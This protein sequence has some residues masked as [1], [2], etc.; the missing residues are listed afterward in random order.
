MTHPDL[1]RLM[2]EI[3]ALPDFHGKRLADIPGE[4]RA[5]RLKWR[6]RFYR[7]ADAGFVLLIWNFFAATAGSNPTW[8]MALAMAAL[9]SWLI[10]F[11]ESRARICTRQLH[12]RAAEQ[13]ARDL[14]GIQD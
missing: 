8:L 14:L 2:A 10:F 11:A 12:R 5:L 4:P 7:L 6:W 1:A 13:L 3:D 9:N